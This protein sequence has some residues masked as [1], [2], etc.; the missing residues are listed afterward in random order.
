[1]LMLR[2]LFKSAESPSDL[3]RETLHRELVG[4]FQTQPELHWKL[5][6]LHPVQHW[7]KD[8]QIRGS[9]LGSSGTSKRS[10]TLINQG[11]IKSITTGAITVGKDI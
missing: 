9:A 8:L 7:A 3:H 6:L 2:I 1:M 11:H 5:D 4:R 10:H